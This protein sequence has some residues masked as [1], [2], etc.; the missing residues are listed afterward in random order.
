MKLHPISDDCREL[1]STQKKYKLFLNHRLN[2]F[3][4]MPL[5]TT[6]VFTGRKIARNKCN[7]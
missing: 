7:K 5:Q 3:L 2:P 4:I 6:K 1:I